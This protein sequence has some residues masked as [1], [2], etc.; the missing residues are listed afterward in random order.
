MPYHPM[1]C[2]ENG[3][4]YSM[5][6]VAHAQPKRTSVKRHFRGGGDAE[7]Q[8]SRGAEGKCKDTTAHTGRTY[9]D[10]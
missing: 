9:F 3:I 1:V 5:C 2:Y 6:Q 10:T 4:A 8:R 7:R